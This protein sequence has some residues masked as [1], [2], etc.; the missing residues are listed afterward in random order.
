MSNKWNAETEVTP[1]RNFRR[2]ERSMC[3][4]NSTCNENSMWKGLSERAACRR[5]SASV[6]ALCM[7]WCLSLTAGVLLTEAQAQTADPR[8]AF[9][10]AMVSLPTFPITNS[11]LLE[12]APADACYYGIGNNAVPDDGAYGYGGVPVEAANCSRTTDGQAKVNQAYIWGLTSGSGGDLWFGTMANTLCVSQSGILGLVFAYQTTDNAWVCEYNKS[13]WFTPV[14]GGSGPAAVIGDLRPS[15]IYW[16]NSSSGLHD[17]TP[18]VPPATQAGWGPANV[19]Q[20]LVY[21]AGLR[22]AAYLPGLGGA[23]NMVVLAGIALN[24]LMGINLFVF[25]ASTQPSSAASACPSTLTSASTSPIKGLPGAASMRPSPIAPATP[26]EA[27]LTEA[28]CG[29]RAL[30]TT[31]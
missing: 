4:E 19:N 3:I 2:K 20:L 23:P 25:N 29:T 5:R 31:R 21:T 16:Y 24:P 9:P 27:Q 26:T 30:K 17:V 28:F 13:A 15:R 10:S 14:Y 11:I 7:V 1:E 12:K 22:S 8:I 18:P 6:R